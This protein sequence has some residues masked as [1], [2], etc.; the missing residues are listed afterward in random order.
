MR[1][2][3]GGIYTLLYISIVS[4]NPAYGTAPFFVILS[5]RRTAMTG[6]DALTIDPGKCPLC[7]QSN[8]CGQLADRPHGSCWCAK[9]EFPPEIFDAIP[10]ESRNKACICANCLA[11]FKKL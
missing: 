9:A 5:G 3:P 6:N 10:A 11:R 4:G 8:S 2:S 1:Q 7:G